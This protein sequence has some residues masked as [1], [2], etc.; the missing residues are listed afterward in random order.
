M[1][2]FMAIDHPLQTINYCV[3]NFFKISQYNRKVFGQYAV[4]LG[5]R[6]MAGTKRDVF[7]SHASEDKEEIVRPLVEACTQDSISC[8]YDEAE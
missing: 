4:Y 7:I 1:S 8:W 6:D 2:I 5:E 3:D